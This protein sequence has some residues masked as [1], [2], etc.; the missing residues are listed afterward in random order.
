MFHNLL[1][2][3][4]QATQ[5]LE[6]AKHPVKDGSGEKRLETENCQSSK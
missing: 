6:F 4:E 1:L 5:R 2:I 3:A